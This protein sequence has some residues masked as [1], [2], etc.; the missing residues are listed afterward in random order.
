MAGGIGS[1]F[2]GLFPN[3]SATGTTIVTPKS[4][5]KILRQPPDVSFPPYDISVRVAAVSDPAGTNVVSSARNIIEGLAPPNSTIWLAYGATGYFTNVTRS[6]AAGYYFFDANLP[7]GTTQVRAFAENSALDYSNIAS[8][9]VTNTNAILSWDAITLH[10]IETASLSAEDASRTLAIVHSAQYD[11]IASTTKNLPTYLV[12]PDR[13]VGASPDAAADAAAAQVLMTLFPNQSDTFAKALKVDLAALQ[14]PKM[15]SVPGQPVTQVG[16]T[17]PTVDYIYKTDPGKAAP[18]AEGQALGQL[19]ATETLALR[20]ND[21]SKVATAA[22][23]IPNPY[24]GQVTPFA[25]SRASQFRPTAP[26]AAGTA[27]FD[28][29]LSEVKS[30]G[31]ITSTTRT[32]AET[33]QAE[34]W[35]DDLGTETNPGHWNAIAEQVAGIRKTN[36]IATARTFAQLDFAMADAGIAAF[37]AKFAYNTD[38]PLTAIRTTTDPTWNSLLVTPLTPSY[39]SAHAAYGAAASQVLGAVYG[40][41]AAFTTTTNPTTAHPSRTYPSFAAAAAED[42]TSRIYGGVNFRFDTT[43][44][45]TLG[46]AVARVAQAKFPLK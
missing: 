7:T 26:P 44:G 38:R 37:D 11:A 46:T 23:I 24:W 6:D 29:A 36:L 42:A 12:H 34:Y 4:T 25:L 17:Q 30:L 13:I 14:A 16:S 43:A 32:A 35:N 1:V 28:K 20:A 15:V 39:V 45:A 5:L 31:Q 9:R 2:S 3:Y 10:A 33:D 19:V 41:K 8:V 22:G 21:N 27:A 40:T 18:V